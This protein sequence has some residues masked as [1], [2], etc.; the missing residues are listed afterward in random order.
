MVAVFLILKGVDLVLILILILIGVDL[1]L[2]AIVLYIAVRRVD[3]VG[4]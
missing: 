2:I 3:L 4:R 1:T